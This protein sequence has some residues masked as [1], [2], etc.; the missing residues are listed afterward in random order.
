LYKLNKASS[1][2]LWN[3]FLWQSL[4][5]AFPSVEYKSYLTDDSVLKKALQ[6]ILKYGFVLVRNVPEEPKEIVKVCTR[7]APIQDSIFGKGEVLC[8]NQFSFTDRAYTNAKLKP[9]TDNIYVKNAAGYAHVLT[10][11][12]LYLGKFRFQVR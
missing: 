10:N 4:G 2:F 11:I 8:T 7:I 5:N 3:E 1:R 9:H 12:Y 6:S